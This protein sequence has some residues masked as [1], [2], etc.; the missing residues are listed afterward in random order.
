MMVSRLLA[1]LVALAIAAPVAAQSNGDGAKK[2]EATG[3]AEAPA[4]PDEAAAAQPEDDPDLDLNLA[5]PDYTVVNMP[6]A[7]RV[8]RHKSAFRVV[9]RFTRPMGSGSFT[10]LLE[11]FFGI[12]AGAQIGLEYRFGLFR[13]TQV[14]IHRTNNRTIELFAQHDLLHQ[15]GN[16]PVGLAVLGT[17]EG[18]NNLRGFDDVEA[19]SPN[20]SPGI[21]AIL[22]RTF[23][24]RA[25]V[26]L[27][28]M[29]VNNTNGLPEELADDNSSFLLGI[30]A[31]VRIRPTV[32]LVG[33]AVPRVAGYDP[34]AHYGAFGIEKRS[35]G[36]SFQLSW[37]NGFGST[38]GQIARGGTS[39]EDWYLGFHISRKFN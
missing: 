24:D 28:P 14:G 2:P 30:A 9:H 15:V 18:T 25:G 7:L 26:Y 6:T 20:Y 37:G 5:Q 32:Y 11:D 38:M 31:R 34:G 10:N 13:G 3:A 19:S 12:D 33:E 17:F 35:G 4:N 1:A 39:S 36:H 29:W 27:T 21:G 22:S 23:G 8:P 16:N